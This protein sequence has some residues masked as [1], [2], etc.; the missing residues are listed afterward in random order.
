MIRVR[1]PFILAGRLPVSKSWLNR[2]FILKSLKPELRIVEWE[3]SEIDGEDVTH[4]RVAL[5]KLAEGAREFQ[6]GESG[7][8]LRFLLARLSR[9]TG[10][11]RVRG[12]DR[13]LQRPHEALVRA[14]ET[15]GTRVVKS[16]DAKGGYFD[17]QSRGWPARDHRIEIDS[18][19]SSQFA[20][21][22]LLSSLG[23]S[24]DLKLEIHGDMRSRGYF[25]M[26]EAMIQAVRNGRRTLVAEP[27]ASSVAT[28]ATVSVAA[29]HAVR[30]RSLKTHAGETREHDDREFQFRLD[31]L[32]SMI[33]KTAQ[34]DR[35]VFDF[36]DQLWKPHSTSILL[37]PLEADLSGAPD[38]FPCL[39]ALAAFAK[40]TS[41]FYGAPHLRLKESDRIRGLARLL[42][43]VGITCRELSDGLEVDGISESDEARY[44]ELRR[45]GL[46]FEFDPESDHRL[47]FAA[48]V[49]AAGGVPIEVTRRG[50]VSKS[51]PLFWAMIEGDAPRIALIGHRGSGKTEAGLRWS[52]ELGPRAMFID[53]DREIERIS[54]RSVR[55]IFETEGEQEFR[56]LEKQA[57]RDVDAESR[58]SLGAVIVSCGAGFD[59]YLIDDSWTRVWFRRATDHD[60]RILSDRPR[61]N[62]GLDPASEFLLRKSERDP[63]FQQTA[64]RVFE[65]AE[66]SVDPSERP[67]VSDLFDT[68]LESS[69][70]S[71]FG[72]AF[73]LLSHHNVSEAIER[74]RRWGVSRI[75]IRN[76]LWPL[77]RTRAWEAFSTI[78]S[79][80]LLI[81]F[82]DEKETDSTLRL[83][84]AWLE[85]DLLPI[86]I[87][88]ALDLSMTVPES[89]LQ[90]ARDGK[91]CLILSWHGSSDS[92]NSEVFKKIE[93]LEAENPRAI[94]KIAV[95]TGD[96]KSLQ[97]FHDWMMASP[98]SRVFLPMTPLGESRPR[99]QWYRAWL[100]SD[101]SLNFWREDDGSSLDQ[102]T[103]SM[104]WRQRRFASK[105]NGV[106]PFTAVLGDPVLHSRTPL[107]HDRFF[108][109]RG[110]P[111][112]A[113]PVRRSEMPGALSFLKKIGLKFAAVTSPLK[114]TIQA[115][116]SI[117]TLA[118][119]NDEWK[120]ANTDD[121]GFL[122]LWKAALA[123]LR[124][125]GEAVTPEEEFGAST[126]VWGGGG[127]LKSLAATLPNA[128]FYSA[129][130]GEL[131]PTAMVPTATTGPRIV[132]W[133]S[134]SVRGAWPDS[135]RPRLIVDLSYT[136]NSLGRAV[137]LETGARY[138]SGL[139]MFEA[140]ARAQREFW[141]GLK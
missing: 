120:T 117:N 23:F 49:L 57:W 63:R 37:T 35:I 38:L 141:E 108:E 18:S 20:S 102:P 138:V 99:W 29:A 106:R 115:G 133:A 4:L 81:S 97:V 74:L 59:P 7:T 56:W 137:A 16:Q 93:A 139:M 62:A 9:E 6:I 73:T 98:Q 17:L 47:A 1:R 135:W 19:E 75:E 109:E 70:I 113:V 91:I 2:A 90:A 111:V 140:Q 88:W 50:V 96:F 45:Q 25:E 30:R 31:E 127:V 48:A 51:L 104:W 112:F 107:E 52:R 85:C 5:E 12:T 116:S 67:W 33:V 32:R 34:P 100:G 118:L 130:Q 44:E 78:P 132:V 64:D 3:P 10:E 129:S 71:N 121:V 8:G 82:R 46:A 42:Q 83:V 11:F 55:E 103:F 124:E 58:R 21:A 14:L 131:R 36:I 123:R 86:A 22:L 61:L 43:T 65:I 28:F 110:L 79:E 89:L 15:L 134:G 24:H 69:T 66:G 94:F 77:S 92:V 105:K 54:G 128:S 41:R 119:V 53:L 68:D 26:S 27:D 122:E 114:E 72:G 80:N 126:A 95:S 101:A 136:E 13:L 76:D 39:A 125:C 84:S 87:D 40:G 60:A